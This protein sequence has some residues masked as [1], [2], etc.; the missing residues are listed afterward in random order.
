MSV[1]DIMLLLWAHVD[2]IR[3]SSRGFLYFLSMFF[4]T[5]GRVFLHLS[6]IW[7][8][9]LQEAYWVLRGFLL[10]S[11]HLHEYL[12][13]LRDWWSLLWHDLHLWLHEEYF[14]ILRVLLAKMGYR[15]DSYEGGI[16]SYERMILSELS[17]LFR[18]SFSRK[19]CSIWR[20]L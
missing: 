12:P 2:E 4:H 16:M 14:M 6:W 11:L 20:S 15:G 5:R 8:M 9:W 13:Y 1:V 19:R 18:S 7:L 17:I 3:V 10:S